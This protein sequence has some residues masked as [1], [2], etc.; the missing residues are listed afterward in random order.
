MGKKEAPRKLAA[1]RAT[2]ICS[3]CHS[4]PQGNMKNDQ[5]VNKENR[6]LI[7]GTSRNDYLVNYTTREDAAQNDFWADGIHSKSHHQQGT[8]L[9]RSKH[10]LNGNQTLSCHTCHDP[11]GKAEVKHQLKTEARD[12]KNTLCATCHKNVKMKEHTLA[13]VGEAHDA[14]TQIRCISCHMPKTVQTGAGLGKGLAADGANYWMNDITSHLF[15]VPRKVA[16]KG[17]EAGKAMP[18]PYTNACGACHDAKS[19]K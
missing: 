1:E 4:R 5:P 9:V 14:D 12:E 3:Q 7:P 13:K 11:H 15:D 18:I 17:V 8:D 19:I 10:Y 16:I 6:M 2:V